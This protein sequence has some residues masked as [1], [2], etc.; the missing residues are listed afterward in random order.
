MLNPVKSEYFSHRQES[1][2]VS[3][4]I[5]EDLPISVCADRLGISPST[6]Q[7]YENGRI[8]P[9]K[10]VMQKMADVLSLSLE[11]VQNLDWPKGDAAAVQL[12]KNVCALRKL[13]R[14]SQA[15]LAKLC[16]VYQ[17]EI[18]SLE[19]GRVLPD[20][21]VLETIAQA[22]GTDVQALTESQFQG[23]DPVIFG[24]NL[25]YHRSR[26]GLTQRA[27]AE[28]LGVSNIAAYESGTSYPPAKCMKAITDFLGVSEEDLNRPVQDVD[29]TASRKENALS[30][31]LK[32]LRNEA[33]LSQRDLADA[34]GISVS[35]LSS[36][37]VGKRFPSD[38]MVRK[39]ADYFKVT[40]DDLLGYS[41][42][43]SFSD[44]LKK[45]R[46]ERDL[47]IKEMARFL[48]MRQTRYSEL[49]RTDI[50]MS[51]AHC[52]PPEDASESSF[53][54]DLIRISEKCGVSINWLLTGDD[55]WILKDGLNGQEP[56]G[57]KSYKGDV[58]Q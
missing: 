38:D 26:T 46:D 13:K 25:A 7:A 2:P 37:E 9:S 54:K 47:D 8:T 30:E 1:E 35:R 17:T 18:S 32:A 34:L 16:G 55:R 51:D 6:W 50:D 31:N 39:I 15:D 27:F 48:Q 40:P 58:V 44:R 19:R 45:L 52:N 36:Y 22:L 14:M 20:H 5:Q 10:A 57:S 24:R 33:S 28:K 56:G 29:Y 11:T 21:S 41:C 53:V 4:R 43:L 42:E 12:G 23:N 49:E 3:R